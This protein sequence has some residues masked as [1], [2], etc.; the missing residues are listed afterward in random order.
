MPNWCE[1]DLVVKGPADQ[2]KAMIDQTWSQLKDSEEGALCPDF[3]KILPYP[4]MFK[5][6]DE[7]SKLEQDQWNAMTPA[8]RSSK[9]YS[10]VVSKD[11]Y[12][13]GGYEWCRDNWGTKWPAGDAHSYSIK[14]NIKDETADG[15]KEVVGKNAVVKVSFNTP[16]CPADPIFLK[17][18][19]MFPKLKFRLAWFECGMAKQGIFEW[20]G[21]EET[22]CEENEYRGNRGG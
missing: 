12:N 17:L 14:N 11:G 5:D 7:K 8:E 22:Y 21:G 16:W 3:E 13:S 20:K 2:I 1:C 6:Q 9:V 18:S 4:Q 19:K 10:E 15:L